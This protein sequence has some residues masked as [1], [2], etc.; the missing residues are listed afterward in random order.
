M[1]MERNYRTRKE[2]IDYFRLLSYEYQKQAHRN[3]D[4]VA[5]AK[6][7]AYE[8]SAF[9]LEHCLEPDL[10]EEMLKYLQIK[11]DMYV[12]LKDEFGI[13][14]ERVLRYYNELTGCVEMVQSLIRKPISW[15]IDCK[16]QI[17]Y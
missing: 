9:E 12:A 1:K 10:K 4:L 8:I 14:H 17:G 15:G 16:I 6:A 11:L 2:Q 7:E 13:A 3:D 5:Q